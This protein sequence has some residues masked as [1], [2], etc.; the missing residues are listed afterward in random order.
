M[1]AIRGAA[2]IAAVVLL[3]SFI[4]V[5][6]SSARRGNKEAARMETAA[7]VAVGVQEV[8]WE[9]VPL[10]AEVPGTVHPL[11]QARLSTKI[12]G[13]VES[14]TVREGDRVQAGQV[15]VALDARDLDAQM[16]QASAELNT[17]R[18][19]Y[20]SAQ[21][22]AKI[23]DAQSQARIKQ[24][25]A[26][27]AAAEAKLDWVRNGLRPQERA[28]AK[29]AVVAAEAAVKLAEADLRRMQMLY[30]EGAIAKQ[31]LD[32]AQT[33]YDTA[34]AQ[35]DIAK[36]S[37]SLAQEG[38]RAE[39]IRS[40]EEGLRQAQA[41]LMQ[42]RSAA[43]QTRIRRQEIAMARARIGQGNAGIAMIQATR[44]YATV[45]APFSGV[46]VQR[47]VDPG[48]M[49]APG[50]PLLTIESDARLRLE[51]TVPESQMR[52]VRL[53][54]T[55]KVI[56]D[57]LGDRSFAGRVAEIV[58]SADTTSRT[59]IVKVDL[60]RVPGLRSGLFG[61]AQYSTGARKAILA[62]RRAIRQHYDLPS[63][64]VVDDQGTAH[65]RLVTLG[66]TCQDRVEIL[67]GLTPGERIIT[68]G[69]DHIADGVQVN[70]GH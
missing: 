56:I 44:S 3:G 34:K 37:Y 49:A 24:A 33:R 1:K 42:A 4:W 7:P 70:T 5:A 51:S 39:E 25:E 28:Q 66:K 17:A 2:G 40:A 52:F 19:A 45:T 12:M 38:S 29:S 69:I 53:G 54:T 14:V 63:V 23:E 30:Q 58:P 65:L 36:E 26:A 22:A 61:R 46:V 9:R 59:F 32:I 57:S 18:A 43:L 64:F 31:R 13:R 67:S 8:S 55:V 47:L 6:R 68:E 60:P 15:L 20:Q 11:M 41:A 48:D 35:L 27:V 16:R 62:P 21:V 50:A 10:E